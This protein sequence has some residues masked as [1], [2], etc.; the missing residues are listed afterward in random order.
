[1]IIEQKWHILLIINDI[2]H[3][4][5]GLFDYHIRTQK[6]TNWLRQQFQ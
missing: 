3:Y 5:N 4:S 6:S 1:M 2:G